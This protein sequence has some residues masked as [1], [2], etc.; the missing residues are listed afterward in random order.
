LLPDDASNRRVRLA[1]G[2]P[3]LSAWLGSQVPIMSKTDDIPTLT[4]IVRCLGDLARTDKNC[5]VVVRSGSLERITACARQYPPAHIGTGTGLMPAHI[6][7]G[8]ASF[9]HLHR[10]WMG[11]GTGVA[12]RTLRRCHPSIARMPLRAARGEH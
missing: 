7:T 3:A 6:C 8:T 11:T 10:D 5:L 9:P 1:S 12:L 2:E 4:L